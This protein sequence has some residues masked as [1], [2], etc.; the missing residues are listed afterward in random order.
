M[1][2]LNRNMV[3]RLPMV[4]SFI[5]LSIFMAGPIIWALYISLTNTSLTGSKALN[6]D[7]IGLQ[8]YSDLLQDPEFPNS[9]WLTLIFVFF[10]AV[11]GQNTLGLLLAL[12]F[13]TASRVMR[14]ISSTLV[15]AAWM[16]PEIVVAFAAYVFFN[17]D[18][19]LNQILMIFGLDP[20]AWLFEA[21]MLSIILA[22]IWRG[23]AFSMMV[24][25]AALDE[26]PEEIIE[27]AK[28]DGVSSSQNIFF[29]T[30][31]IIKN[32]INTNLMLITLQTLSV[33]ALV[34]TM[35]QGGP[36]KRSNTLPV[37]A[38]DEAFRV[39]QIGYGAAI[40]VVMIVI[41][42]FF[43]VIYVRL[44]KSEGVK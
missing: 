27:A 3:R 30:L 19:T 34:Y 43:S 11:V 16:L 39:S 44:L 26:V 1:N 7:F 35:T 24:Y 20:V 13:K 41:G 36:S 40:S 8:N 14:R 6:P 33:F 9:L 12:S 42:V 5:L 18:G 2:T 31:P 10:S 4:P 29:V 21:P 37:F 25:I 22:N 15:M 38:Y 17:T 28:L 32:S 23:T